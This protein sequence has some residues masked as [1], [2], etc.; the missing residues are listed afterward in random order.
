MRRGE[1]LTGPWE[2]E[3]QSSN[4]QQREKQ[5]QLGCETVHVLRPAA[6]KPPSPSHSP[7]APHARLRKQLQLRR[8]HIGPSGNT[9]WRFARFTRRRLCN[10]LQGLS[11]LVYIREL[12]YWQRDRAM[13]L[14]FCI[15]SRDR[16]PNSKEAHC[17]TRTDPWHPYRFPKV[18]RRARNPILLR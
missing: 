6:E 1:T 18:N 15:V 17:K 11:V 16:Q 5:A 14:G 10:S 2:H 8:P 12:G 7:H 3:G 13:V 9:D 4:L